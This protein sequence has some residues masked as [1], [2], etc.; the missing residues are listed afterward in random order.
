MQ[1]RWV[2]AVGRGVDRMALAPE[3]PRELLGVGE[4]A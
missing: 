1:Y 4:D 3:V 2:R